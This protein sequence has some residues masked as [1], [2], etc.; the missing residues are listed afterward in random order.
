MLNAARVAFKPSREEFFPCLCQSMV[1]MVIYKA[2]CLF[3]R[4]RLQILEQGCYKVTLTL[5]LTPLH[6]NFWLVHTKTRL[7]CSTTE[8][9]TPNWARGLFKPSEPPHAYGLESHTQRASNFAIYQQRRRQRQTFRNEW[10]PMARVFK[11]PCS[12]G[13]LPLKRRLVC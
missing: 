8:R 12:D 6:H 11:K 13:T 10:L 5:A 3:L 7:Y 2:S 9:R 1:S 4:S